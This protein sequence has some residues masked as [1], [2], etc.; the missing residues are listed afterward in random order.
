MSEAGYFEASAT[1]VPLLLQA[2]QQD[3]DSDGYSP[4]D[5]AVLTQ[6]SAPVLLRNPLPTSSYSFSPAYSRPFRQAA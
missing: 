3:E 2:L 6:I 1:Y 4:T 5:P